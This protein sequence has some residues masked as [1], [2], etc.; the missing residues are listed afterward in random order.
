MFTPMSILSPFESSSDCLAGFMNVNVDFKKPPKD[1][2]L[3]T[4]GYKI[5]FKG[6][7]PG[8]VDNGECGYKACNEIFPE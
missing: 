6:N 1:S 4:K 3:E 7:T 5:T 8:T 2:L